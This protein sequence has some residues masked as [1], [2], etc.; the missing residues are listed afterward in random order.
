MC[1]CANILTK[2]S[3]CKKNHSNKK[4]T[5][6]DNNSHRILWWCMCMQKSLYEIA[7]TCGGGV[8][9]HF[10]I[11]NSYR[12]H[13]AALSVHATAPPFDTDSRANEVA[14][15]NTSYWI[16]RAKKWISIAI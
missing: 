2:T 12:K 6:N 7:S 9:A 3:L 11:S 1:K 16:Q 13:I 14:H 10:E 5:N 4:G 15:I 8:S